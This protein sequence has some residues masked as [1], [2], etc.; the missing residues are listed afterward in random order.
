MEP[1]EQPR[2]LLER[3]TNFQ[4]LA[5][6]SVARFF[7][8]LYPRRNLYIQKL[9]EQ[10]RWSQKK[11]VLRDYQLLGVIEDGGRGLWRGCYWGEET[12]FAVLDID[13]GSSYHNA[14][15]LKKL[16]EILAGVSLTDTAYRSSE[17]GGW[18]LYLPFCDWVSSKEIETSLKQ[19]LKMQGYELKGGTLE[20]FPSGNALRLPLQPG[21]AWLTEHGE[22]E[23]R[24]E[25]IDRDEALRRFLTDLQTYENNWSEAKDLIDSELARHREAQEAKHKETISMEGFD[26][27]Y[28]ERGKDQEL[29]E[30]G[31]KLW[32]AGLTEKDK[33]MMPYWQ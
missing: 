14:Q 21:F 23:T 3:K 10:E 27:L 6:E 20:V 7:L 12:R 4:T 15:E 2:T 17:S 29:W 24:R 16:R 11:G 33:G 31:Q 8:S 32:Q 9:P 13:H 18:H 26:H 19:F 30:L 25:D 1:F 28:D 5:P 22:V